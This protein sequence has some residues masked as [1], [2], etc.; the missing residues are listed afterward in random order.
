MSVA[1]DPERDGARSTLG[2][3]AGLLA[4]VAGLLG[5]GY[6]LVTAVIPYLFAEG[7]SLAVANAPLILFWS[8]VI[9]ALS[10]GIGYW[11]WTERLWRVWA[12]AVAVSTLA[13]L[14]LFSIGRAIVPFAALS[15]VAAALLTIESRRSR[16]AE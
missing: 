6:L 4:M 11:T 5:A 12:L 8:I 1:N 3:G 2:R 9:V 14:S 16:V 7:E 15:V 10:L 13:V